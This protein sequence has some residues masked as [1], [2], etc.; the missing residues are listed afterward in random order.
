MLLLHYDTLLLADFS[1]L[2][3]DVHD[4]GHA[5]MPR[6]LDERAAMRPP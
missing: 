6:D 4:Y 1:P 3:A 5:D 2:F